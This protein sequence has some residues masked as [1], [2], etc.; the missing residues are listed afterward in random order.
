[1]CS[2]KCMHYKRRMINVQLKRLGENNKNYSKPEES[3]RKEIKV[4]TLFMYMLFILYLINL[5][6]TVQFIDSII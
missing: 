4:R 5:Y 1:M 2:L 6:N 3:Q